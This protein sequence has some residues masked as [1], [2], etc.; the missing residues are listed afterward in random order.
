MKQIFKTITISLLAIVVF[1]C[2]SKEKEGFK[3]YTNENEGFSISYPEDW[4][5]REGFGK[6]ASFETGSIVVFQSPSEG[7]KDLFRENVHVFTETLPDSV[8]DIESY[9]NYS[10]NYLPNQLNE[11]EFIEN[12]KTIINGEP[13]HWVIFKYSSRLQLVNSLGYMFYRDGH[14][15][16]ITCTSRPEDFM[17][18]RR[19]FEDIATSIEFK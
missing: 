7:K 19:T 18:F 17:K 1:S 10:K 16:V 6:D 9:Y 14:G 13:A 15:L 2:G 8:I 5:Y 12:R 4:V 11:L 3:T